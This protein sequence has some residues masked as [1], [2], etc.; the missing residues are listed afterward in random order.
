MYICMIVHEYCF[1]VYFNSPHPLQ[2]PPKI[3]G[4][5]VSKAVK[6]GKPTLRVTWT[7][8]QNVANLSQYCVQYKRNVALYWGYA[9]STQPHPKT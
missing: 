7:A 9:V 2:V 4:V 3:T 5:S 8:L 1:I 6:E